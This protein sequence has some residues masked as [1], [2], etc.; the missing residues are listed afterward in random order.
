MNSLPELRASADGASIKKRSRG[1]GNITYRRKRGSDRHHTIF[2]PALKPAF[3]RSK[4]FAPRFC[5]AKFDIP[6][7]R[8]VNE[9]TTRL[10]SL[11][12]A[13]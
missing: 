9:V 7:P 1:S 3:I 6:F 2:I 12:A 5:E 10:L 11:M 4:A 8:V 13:E